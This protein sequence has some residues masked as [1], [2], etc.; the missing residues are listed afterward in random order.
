MEWIYARA[1]GGIRICGAFGEKDTLK[2]PEE[3]G[4][5][6]VTEIGPYAFSASETPRRFLTEKTARFRE[7]DEGV[8]E[9][10]DA[11]EEETEAKRAVKGDRLLAVS[12]PD[13]VKVIGDYAFY[14]CGNL[15]TISFTDSL[16]RIGS[17]AFMGCSMVRE[18]RFIRK[19]EKS[20]SLCQML[21]ELR[22]AL[23][24][25]IQERDGESCLIFPEYYE[26]SVENIPAR[27]L[28]THV[29]GTGYRYR[30]CFQEGEIDYRAY[31][32]LFH[33]AVSQEPAQVL[34]ELAL[35][36]LRCPKGLSAEAKTGYLSYFSSHVREAGE[37]LLKQDDLD[38]IR[39]VAEAGGIGMDAGET[40]EVSFPAYETEDE[41]PADGA[42]DFYMASLGEGGFG[43]S[44]VNKT[45]SHRL[46][47]KRKAAI[48]AMMEMAGQMGR[49]EC[50]GFLMDFKHRKETADGAK[51]VFEL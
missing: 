4:G 7:K 33:L 46:T 10:T 18:L 36:R 41:P 8:F 28:E 2:V 11:K 19:R 12:L 38:S 24:V 16:E 34:A 35:S 22:Y 47:G 9:K 44:P 42:G 32:G 20:R 37:Y 3:I 45:E 13:T 48:D 6:P 49:T 43:G 5:C 25:T 30:Q 31:D 39:L 17:G 50:L 29:H 27:I 23:A 40:Q 14:G 15:E 26:V 21:S 51:K 1:A